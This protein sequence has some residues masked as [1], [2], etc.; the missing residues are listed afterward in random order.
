MYTRGG[1]VV[2]ESPPIDTSAVGSIELAFWVRRGAD[3]F[4]EDPD[5]REDLQLGYLDPAGNFVV[6]DTFTGA[7]APGQQFVRNYV[8]SDA[9]ALHAGFRIR[10]HQLK[11]G[12]GRRRGITVDYWH[13]D[14]VIVREGQASTPLQFGQCEDFEGGLGS[15][16]AAGRGE[17]G[18]GSHTANSGTRS[19]YLRHDNVSVTSAA[20]DADR[21]SAVLNVWVRRGL[22]SFSEDPDRREDLLFEYLDA[23]GNWRSLKNYRGAGRAGQIYEDSLSLPAAALHAQLQLRLQLVRGKG[24][25]TTYWHVDDLC[26]ESDLLANYWFDETDWSVDQVLDAG[27]AAVHGRAQGDAQT[28]IADPALA[29]TPGTCRYGTFD[30]GQDLVRIPH[31]E[32]F[33][34]TDEL[35]V[36]AWVYLQALPARGAVRTIFSKHHNFEINIDFRGR[37]QWRWNSGRRNVVTSRT[38]IRAGQWHHIA[39]SFSKKARRQYVYID[40]VRD[41]ELRGRDTRLP[42]NTM[43]IVIGADSNTAGREW[44]GYIDEVYLAGAALSAAQVDRIRLQRRP[45]VIDQL[46]YFDVNVITSLSASTCVPSEVEIVARDAN[47]SVFTAYTGEVTIGATASHGDWRLR[48]DNGAPSSDPA[49]GS[50][51]PGGADGGTASYQFA[52]ADAGT[53]RLFLFNSHAENTAVTVVDPTVAASASNSAALNFGNNAFV[54]E[55]I[56]CTGATCPSNGSLEVVAG[57][58]HRFKISMFEQDPGAPPGTCRVAPGYAGNRALKAWIA[59]DGDDPSGVL[60]ALAEASAVLGDGVAPGGA[61]LNL[62]FSDR[63]SSG[64]TPAG[65]A[66]FTLQ[67][68]DVGKYRIHIRDDSG[69]FAQGPIAGATGTATVRPFGLVLTD[70]TLGG[71]AN[72][73]A[74]APSGPGSVFGA[75]GANFAAVLSAYAWQNGDDL[76]N[77]GHVDAGSDL[78]DNAPT[79][80]F[81][82]PTQIAAVL[83]TPSSSVGGVLG[84]FNNGDVL[85]SE[86]TNGSAQLSDLQYMEVGSIFL[87]ALAQDYLNSVGVTVPGDSH[88]DGTSGV[89]G[90]FI[91]DRFDFIVSTAP[92]LQAACSAAFTYVDQAFAYGNIPRLGARALAADGATVLQNYHDFSS[93]GGAN[94]WRL[95]LANGIDQTFTDSG[96]PAVVALQATS[97]YSPKT[98]SGVHG[99]IEFALSAALR[100]ADRALA[101]FGPLAPFNAAI[102]L[103]FTV[104]DT[105]GARGVETFAPLSFPAPE[106]RWGR[107]RVG[108]GFGPELG[109]VAVPLVSE[110]FDGGTWITN[111]ADICTTVAT[112]GLRLTSQVASEATQNDGDIDVTD[113]AICAGSG[114]AVASIGNAPL[115]DGNAGLMF[116]MSAPAVRC[117]GDVDIAVDLGAHGLGHL[118]FDW[119][120]DGIPSDDPRGRASFGIFNGRAEYIYQREPWD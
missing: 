17:A 5:R 24:A 84:R 66:E 46:G 101:P 56:T 19:L 115:V 55:P 62:D 70:L 45:C 43:P 59:R 29:G 79:P 120:G 104:T 21:S 26:L 119:N 102:T 86:F 74:D 7:G 52:S 87:T 111:G 33:N 38:R 89:V 76:D 3:Q 47:G 75:A 64:G 10:V 103:A 99:Q 23:G 9:S 95:E 73:R 82:W 35:T 60:P 16:T 117:T 108:T 69:S 8:L 94:W 72:P 44:V 77:D 91:P 34:V 28:D 93:A 12:D 116:T 67:T 85:A 68:A 81:A 114:V 107:L 37:V 18:V 88:N 96:A 118:S 20:I 100:Y 54:L 22:D 63:S 2:V 48:D 65:S 27:P 1:Q 25:G 31:N 36:M 92:Q 4:S 6:L 106:Q 78:T 109:P 49:T 42:R 57:R 39:V 97:D 50:L 15:W 112:T 90:R 61:N 80:S 11:G 58:A 32:I 40:A 30:G 83:N 41:Q 71:S 51:S 110:Y 113:A 105:D 53:V 13:V 14:D 98:G